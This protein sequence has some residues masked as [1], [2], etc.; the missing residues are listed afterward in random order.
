M[1]SRIALVRRASVMALIG[2][3]MGRKAAQAARR[4]QFAFTRIHHGAPL[5]RGKQSFRERNRQKLIGTEAGV[6]SFRPVEN[7]KTALGGSI[8]KSTKAFAGAQSHAFELA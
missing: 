6:V 4:E 2:G 8:P 1:I 7:V 3:I 5:L